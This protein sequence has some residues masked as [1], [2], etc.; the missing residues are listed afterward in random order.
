MLSQAV[1]SEIVVLRILLISLPGGIMRSPCA[2]AALDPPL[3]KILIPNI[4]MCRQLDLPRISE[5]EAAIRS[6]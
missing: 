1:S 3:W 4:I 6:S 2:G 5:V